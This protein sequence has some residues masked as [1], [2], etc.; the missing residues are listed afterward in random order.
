MRLNTFA[1]FAALVTLL[2]PC[3]LFGVD[4]VILI[5]QNKA[6][7]GNVTPGD[8]PGFPIIISQSGSYRLDSN[9]ILPTSTNAIEISASNVT[10]DL[11]GFS[12]ICPAPSSPV[13]VGIRF[14][15]SVSD[16]NGITIRNGLISG[17]IPIL[18]VSQT[19]QAWTL[20]SL[21]LSLGIPGSST[22][23][24]FGP[25][26]RVWHVTAI[27]VDLVLNSC[28]AMIVES[29]ARSI[30]VQNPSPCVLVNNATQFYVESGAGVK[31]ISAK[32]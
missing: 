22:P 21:V 30:G 3:A 18:T 17:F 23:I 14:T 27:S 24:F 25:Y 13:A 20:E 32:Q 6:L 9:L 19:T 11:N 26:S 7:A 28:P 31:Y 4:G 5:D 10:I 15:G 8:T 2:L 16:N 1:S 12:I 29:I